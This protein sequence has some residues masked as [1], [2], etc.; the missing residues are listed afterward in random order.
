MKN[1]KM[2]ALA[3][4]LV[5]LAACV[6][7]IAGAVADDWDHPFLTKE[8]YNRIAADPFQ[9]DKKADADRV[10]GRICDAKSGKIPQADADR[11]A[12]KGPQVDETAELAF[13]LG[14]QVLEAPPGIHDFYPLGVYG[15]TLNDENIRIYAGYALDRP[16]QGAV[17]LQVQ[18]PDTG[19]SLSRVDV[20]PGTGALEIE[21][22]EGGRA[23]L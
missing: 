11:E 7:V 1:K 12:Q 19:L 5:I 20:P 8:A 10:A 4:P 16:E 3:I 6:P 14:F 23:Y 21:K 2:L 13:N 15:A 18:R 17:I 22:V 9:Q